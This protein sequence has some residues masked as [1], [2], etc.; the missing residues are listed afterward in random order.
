MT[1]CNTHFFLHDRFRYLDSPQKQQEEIATQQNK[2]TTAAPLKP[3]YKGPP[4]KPNRYGIRPG[5]RW[6]GIDRGN[7]FED[8]LLTSVHSRGRKKEEAYKWSSADM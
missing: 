3:T 8:R 4:P 2:V 1:S 6:D 7:G 5:Y